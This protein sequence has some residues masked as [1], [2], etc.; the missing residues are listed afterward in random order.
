MSIYICSIAL[1]PSGPLESWH[2]VKLHLTGPTGN[3]HLKL[4]FCQILS[5]K[6]LEAQPSHEELWTIKK[7]QTTFA[8]LKL[9]RIWL[10]CR[11][12]RTA[13]LP[14]HLTYSTV[15]SGCWCIPWRQCPASHRNSLEKPGKTISLTFHR[16]EKSCADK[17]NKFMPQ[18]QDH[19]WKVKDE[20]LK[21][22]M[23]VK[24]QYK[25]LLKTIWVELDSTQYNSEKWRHRH[26]QELQGSATEAIL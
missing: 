19:K 4:T 6:I 15:T 23:T 11:T 22:H 20:S 3:C 21:L 14:H 16:M 24:N 26:W 25:S 7:C 8:E 2:A 1:R 18:I 17:Q 5:W 10:Q 13:D 9:S 12:G